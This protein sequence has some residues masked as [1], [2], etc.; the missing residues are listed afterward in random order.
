M[1]QKAVETTVRALCRIIVPGVIAHDITIGR[2]AQAVEAPV[3]ITDNLVSFEDLASSI[4]ASRTG[5]ISLSCIS[6]RVRGQFLGILQQRQFRTPTRASCGRRAC[7]AFSIAAAR[8]GI[9]D[10]VARIGPVIRQRIFAII[11]DRDVGPDGFLKPDR[12]RIGRIE[13]YRVM[14]PRIVFGRSECTHS[15]LSTVPWGVPREIQLL[16]NMAIRC[17]V[18]NHL[19]PSRHQIRS[20][21]FWRRDEAQTIRYSAATGLGGRSGISAS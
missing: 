9:A 17:R 3:H 16:A 2:H 13:R 14:W 1:Q 20:S 21:D 6:A 4:P 7:S 10:Q 8:A 11:E 5:T 18:E 12:Q 15:T 19:V